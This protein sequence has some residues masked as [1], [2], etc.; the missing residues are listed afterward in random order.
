MKIIT[1]D[2]VIV[3]AGKDKGKK[4]VVKRVFKKRNRVIV[5]GVNMKIKHMKPSQGRP[6]EKIE[7]EGPIQI[8]N[9]KLLCPKTKKPT[10]VGYKKLE[11]GEKI[12]IAKVSGEVIPNKSYKKK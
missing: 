12:R 1:N 6:G 9:I 10:R 7:L 3:V 2:N 4:S 5:E 11:S 8:S